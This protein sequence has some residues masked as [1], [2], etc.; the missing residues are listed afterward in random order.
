M[1]VT[2][3][4]PARL[5]GLFVLFQ[6]VVLTVVPAWL[7]TS[8]PL[9]V[10]EGWG[11]APHWLL[12]T[13]KHPPMPAWFLQAGYLLLPDRIWTPY[14]LSQ[15]A[16]AATY[17]LVYRTGRL[18][19]DARSAAA[20]TLLL[21]GSL[22]LTFLTLEF[23]H[24]VIQLP[25]WAAII[26]V[27][28]RILRSP[29][30]TALWLLLGV[31]IGCGMYAKYSIIVLA[32]VA[33]LAGLLFPATRPQYRT[34]R[35]WLTIGAALLVFAPHLLW[36]ATHEFKPLGY[37]ADR[38]VEK[39]GA[40]G[41]LAFLAAQLLNHMPMLV[42]LAVAGLRK[43]PRPQPFAL[44]AAQSLLF[45][46]VFTFGPVLL[47]V[48]GSALT[49]ASPRD[50]WGM[51]MFTMLGLWIVAEFARDWP[52]DRLR[53]LA[54][55]AAG[56]VTLAAVAFAA[57]A[58]RATDHRPARPFWPMQQIAGQAQ[59][60]WQAERDTPLR[61]VG[62]DRWLAGLVSV[63][64]SPA[65][66]V[67]VTDDLSDSPW[68]SPQHLAAEGMLYLVQ[69]PAEPPADRCPVHGPAHPIDPAQPHLP[70]MAAFVCHPHAGR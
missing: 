45:L 48:L 66:A 46:R 43:L 70:P 52:T 24:N 55:A 60:A 13:H 6:L 68:I 25:F 20:G 10:V 34:L 28:A 21:A 14:L 59:A 53:R 61:I 51:P 58:W 31:L 29:Q 16:V 19:M 35:P 22:Y 36:L 11:W 1:S 47:V 38:S 4:S 18:L 49:G 56:I 33:G 54:G 69:P 64:L 26:H 3:P 50:M 27:F 32:V 8:P 30:R 39:A 23:N 57:Q 63:A 40:W 41:P 15:L 42:L 67:A 12:G 5:V 17:L 62:G 2:R 37:A 65:P 9:D 7:S 44:P